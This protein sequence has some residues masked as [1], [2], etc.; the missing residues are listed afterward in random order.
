M[1]STKNATMMANADDLAGLGGSLDRGHRDER[2]TGGRVGTWTQIGDRIRLLILVE[3]MAAGAV[4]ISA[5]ALI[6][7]F[8]LCA[9]CRGAPSPLVTSRLTSSTLGGVCGLHAGRY[10]V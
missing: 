3:A 4:L 1:C 8:R 9:V 5:A 10:S 2:L 6:V 7:R